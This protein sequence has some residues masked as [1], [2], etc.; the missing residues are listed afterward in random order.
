MAVIVKYV[1]VRDG[2]EDMIFTTKKEADAYDKM[3]DIAE[4]L[5]EFLQT[6]EIDIAAEQLDDLTFFMAQ[7]R[8][9]IGSI[10]KGVAPD[11]A[12][13]TRASKDK[14]EAAAEVESEVDEPAAA[15]EEP[16]EAPS[17]PRAAK[18]R[19]AA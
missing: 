7:H 14:V 11:A 5:H 1:V 18:S 10:L 4:Q 6:S 8:D 13:K 16:A 19:A 2:K 15:E 12:K 3:L 17:G 9:Q